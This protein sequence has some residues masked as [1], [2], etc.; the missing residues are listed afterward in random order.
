ML[1]LSLELTDFKHQLLTIYFSIVRKL[2]FQFL[3][4]FENL[5]FHGQF[6]VKAVLL[7]LFGVQ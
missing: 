7:W 6:D 3:F 5:G 2:N 4:Y 1:V